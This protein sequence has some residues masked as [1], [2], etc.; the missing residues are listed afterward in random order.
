MKLL[1]NK[2]VVGGACIAAAAVFSFVLLPG[3]YKSRGKTEIVIKPAVNIAA[4]TQIDETML[5][6]AEV[7]SF[8]LPETVI[9]DKAQVIGKFI[10][11]D[12]TTDELLLASKL[13]DSAAGG[14]LDS[15]AANGQKLVTISLPSVAAGVGNHLKAGDFV[16]IYAYID[17][18]T[19]IYDELRNLE[20]YSVENGEAIPLDEADEET[21][22]IA[23]TL[24]LVV[25][26]AQAE[27]LVYAEYAGKL[28]AVFERRGIAG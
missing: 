16:S 26:D 28:H 23:E 6:E 21:E 15:I 20:V 19:V 13:S 4:G 5:T 9:Q 11:C 18:E 27:K 24:T 17:N 25:N 8:G 22:K 10:N 2:M 12:I 1:Q 3:M 7:G 14:R